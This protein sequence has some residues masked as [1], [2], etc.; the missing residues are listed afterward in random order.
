MNL[1]GAGHDRN[2]KHMGKD[3]PAYAVVIGAGKESIHA[4]K[5]AKELGLRVL[6]LDGDKEAGGLGYADEAFAVDI[7]DEA[8]VRSILDPY[9]PQL[10]LLLPV[11]IGRYLTITGLMNDH[12]ELPGVTGRA[13]DAC[14][15][16]WKFHRILND[17]GLRDGKACLLKQGESHGSETLEGMDIPCILKPRYGS[18]SRG[19]RAYHDR[20]ELGRDLERLR[21]FEEDYVLE[22]CVEGQEYG[23]D[24][25]VIDRTFHLILLRKKLNTPYPHRQCVGYLSVIDDGENHGFFEAVKEHIGKIVTALGVNNCL[26]HGDI[27]RDRRG[28]PF[29][30][31]LSARPSGH[32]LNDRFTPLVTGVDET[33]E[34]IRYALTG[35]AGRFSFV[36]SYTKRMLIRFFDFS[37]VEVRSIP[38]EMRLYEKYPLRDYV[39]RL[40]FGE[41]LGS[42]VDGRIMDRGYFILEGNGDEEL[43]MLGRRLLGE[44]EVEKR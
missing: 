11:P 44:F 16:K 33:E 20:S 38:D 19:V 2:I 6:A 13:A 40:S 23:I 25:A 9:R 10:R 30:I 43:L 4:I 42:V 15:D 24:G 37:D 14:T 34:F 27:I 5:K 29:I 21:P 32:Y 8:L 12:Y 18:G 26:I 28:L 7:R 3:I 17:R 31:E 41:R 39:C 36:P 22:T 1:R 35:T